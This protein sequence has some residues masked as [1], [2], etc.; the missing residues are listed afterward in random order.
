[1]G[2]QTTI[3]NNITTFDSIPKTTIPTELKPFNLWENLLTPMG[4]GTY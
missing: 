4:R 1:M 3:S 2:V